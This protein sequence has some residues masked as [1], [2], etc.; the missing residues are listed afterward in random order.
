MRTSTRAPLRT[1]HPPT[2]NGSKR[3]ARST[4]PKPASSRAR[5]HHAGRSDCN[6]QFQPLTS[7]DSTTRRETSFVHRPV[8]LVKRI[9]VANRS[10]NEAALRELGLTMPQYAIM[11]VLYEQSGLSGA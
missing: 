3:C 1:W 5:I 10:R 6:D 7:P 8:Y 4:T 2:L 11:Y 9:S